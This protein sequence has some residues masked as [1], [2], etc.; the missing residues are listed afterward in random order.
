[1]KFRGSE[2]FT[3]TWKKIGIAVLLF[4]ASVILHNVI[5][6]LA[7]HFGGRDFWGE[8]G[9]EPF[10]FAIAT[11][12]IPGYLIISVLYTVYRKIKR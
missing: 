7:I 9:D 5:D 3:L 1:M 2:F 11:L 10:F 6:A 4:V 8:V 12:V